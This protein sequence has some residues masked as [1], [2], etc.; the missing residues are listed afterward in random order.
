MNKIVTSVGLLALG[1]SALQAA[2][3]SALNKMQDSKA[4]S[5]SA[6]LRGFY[7]DNLS[8]TANN[9]VETYGVQISPSV[10][11]GMPGEQTSFNVGYGFTAKFYDKHP[12]NSTGKADYTHQFDAN[13]SHA[14]N[15]NLDV[16]LYES[17]VV[18]QEPD[19]VRD[20]AGTQR[21]KGNNIRNFAGVD[22][23]LTATDLLGFSFGYH[24]SLYDYADKSSYASGTF[25]GA[26]VNQPSY[27]GLLD[28]IEH[29]VQL[30]SNWKLSPETVGI[31]GYTYSQ[32]GYTGNETILGYVDAIGGA[33]R[34]SNSRDSRGHTFYVGGQHIFSPTLSGVLK[35]GAQYTDYFN[36]PAGDSQWSPYVQGN[37]TYALQT[38][39]TVDLGVKY[40]RT[41]A[42]VAGAGGSLVLDS[43]TAV[44]YGTLK[45]EIVSKLVGS[46]T[47][48]YNHSKY[49]GGGSGYDGQTYDFYQ[50]GL[51]LGYEFNPN[52][53]GHI[54]YNYDKVRSDLAGRN[55]D[56][57]RIY[58]GVTAGF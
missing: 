31:V 1:V 52:I 9:K 13:L 12:L 22:F 10:D 38:T 30:D 46:A 11:F 17:F 33:E 39:T 43:E 27:S 32:I 57:N 3:S 16:A 26:G 5:V 23:N 42:N 45:H 7:D 25:V 4:W 40:S 19:M 58:L 44:V 41:A 56:R 6:S 28:R 47:A 54:G 48:T 8:T 18:G 36:A 2:E 35:V 15:P 29:E 49:N 37:I 55:Y 34:K 14:F 50:L 21:I 24:N 20:A 51:D 53:S